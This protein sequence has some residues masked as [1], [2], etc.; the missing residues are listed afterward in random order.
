MSVI[1]YGKPGCTNCDKAK[2][3]C[4]IK[5]IEFQYYNVGQD[6]TVEQLQERVGMPVH[7]LPQIFVMSDGFAEYVGG[8]DE[9]RNRMS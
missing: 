8:Y 5:S 9:F 3:L 2:M 1:I 4:N 6:V 7:T